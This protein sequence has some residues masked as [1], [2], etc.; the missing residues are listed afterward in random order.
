M[1]DPDDLERA[2]QLCERDAALYQA[3]A[4]RAVQQGHHRAAAEFLR[5]WQTCEDLAR[6]IRELRRT[7]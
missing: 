1:D 3:Y 7:H 4:D 2:A 6:R 5:D